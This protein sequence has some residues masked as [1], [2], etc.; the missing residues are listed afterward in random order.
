MGPHATHPRERGFHLGLTAQVDR[1]GRVQCAW[2]P[3]ARLVH[4]LV[5]VAVRS[6]DEVLKIGSTGGTLHGRWHK[7]LKLV[8]AGRGERRYRP[9]EWADR[10]SWR[11]EVC[12]F[13]FAVWFKP[14]ER[15]TLAYLD[16]H[17]QIV[18]LRHA[19]ED[20]LDAY[21]CPRIGKLLDS[22]KRARTC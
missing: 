6:D 2:E 21:Y 10:D 17:T 3:P 19:E 7:I 20:Y 8:A 14:A 4:D 15:H 12:G 16:G 9:N 13:R 11:R 18:S 5:Y 1:D 22:R